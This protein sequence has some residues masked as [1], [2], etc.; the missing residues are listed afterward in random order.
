MGM[1]A[2]IL[3][4]NQ[5]LNSSTHVLHNIFAISKDALNGEIKLIANKGVR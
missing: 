4:M 1:L 3:L 2:N 5:Q